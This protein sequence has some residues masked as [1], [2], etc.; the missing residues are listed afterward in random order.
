ML[1]PRTLYIG[2]T[3][4]VAQTLIPV[5]RILGWAWLRAIAVTQLGGVALRTLAVASESVGT[6]DLLGRLAREVPPTWAL[7]SAPLAV[8]GTALA[9]QRL[10]AEGSLLALGSLGM[11]TTHVVI[12][13]LVSGLLVGAVAETVGRAS[14]AT[15]AITRAAGGWYIAGRA[16]ADAGGG[17]VGPLPDDRSWSLFGLFVTLSSGV[18]VGTGSGAAVIVS[19]AAVLVV[20]LVRRSIGASALWP[21]MALVSWVCLVVVRTGRNASWWRV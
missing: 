4:W 20:D 2:R 3:G 18:S 1:L 8:A 5:L 9:V 12:M 14:A 10:R 15:T 6:G 11:R 21:T 13:S 19:S 7:I 16:V 17:G